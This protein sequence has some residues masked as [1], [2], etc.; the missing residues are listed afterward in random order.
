[1]F[2]FRN[3]SISL[4]TFMLYSGLS[5]LALPRHPP[6]PLPLTSPLIV[7]GLSSDGERLP[8]SVP[9]RPLS[10]PGSLRRVALHCCEV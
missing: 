9:S 7:A 4:S 2:V 5:H 1:M 6:P 3:D 10:S 8:S